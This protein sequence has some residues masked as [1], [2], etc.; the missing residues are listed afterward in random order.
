MEHLGSTL[1]AAPARN[2]PQ[3]FRWHLSGAPLP[4][5][6]AALPLGQAVRAA[7]YDAAAK[8]GIDR[9]PDEFHRDGDDPRHTH[10]F[11]LPE[12]ADGD[13]LLDHVLLFAE[14]G[15]PPA[16][17]PVLAEPGA[18]WLGRLG[19]WALSP[20]WMGRRA[21]GALFGPARR[22]QA[23]SA[24]V[25]SRWQTRKP[26]AGIRDGRAPEEQL[27]Q[28]IVSRGLP[29]P[30]EIAWPPGIPCA[31][32]LIGPR[33]FTVAAGKRRPPGDWSLGFPTLTFAAPVWGPLA[34]GF[35]AHFGLGLLAPADGG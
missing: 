2:G 18:V 8:R 17:L 21:A 14:Y 32:G 3:G 34:F 9:L 1:R 31:G 19:R 12:D 27:R 6:G 23:A 10:A 15:L 24:Y 33:G 28:D 35:G 7:I 22:W 11:W 20:D 4:P 25:T 16:L 26:G 13:G 30:E 29:P 5:L